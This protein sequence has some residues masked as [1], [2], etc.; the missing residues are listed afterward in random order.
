LR[1]IGVIFFFA[2]AE[3]HDVTPDPG[4]STRLQASFDEAVNGY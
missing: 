3:R 1:K 2:F 4:T